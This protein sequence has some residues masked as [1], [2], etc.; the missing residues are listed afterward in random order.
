MRDSCFWKR[1]LVLAASAA[2]GILVYALLAA[3]VLELTPSAPFCTALAVLLAGALLLG[4]VLTVPRCVC[5]PALAEAWSCW[6]DLAVCG[7]GAAILAACLIS[8][9]ESPLPLH[10]ALALTA[11]LLALLLG[12]LAGFLR[13]YA[14]SWTR[15]SGRGCSCPLYR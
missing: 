11:A 7:G 6:G 12:S 3:G 8:F 5:A 15:C 13:R 9:L 14:L 2:L 1:L 10:I 4:L